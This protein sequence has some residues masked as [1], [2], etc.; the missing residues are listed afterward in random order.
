MRSRKYI[1]MMM[2]VII[3]IS[4]CS[5]AQAA[6]IQPRASEHLASFSAFAFT[7][8][9]SGQVDIEYNISTYNIMKT[10]GVSQIVI[11]K[12]NRQYV[13]TIGGSTSNGLLVSFHDEHNDV[14]TYT[15]TPGTS[16]YAVVTIY[17]Y[18]GNSSDSRTITTNTAKAA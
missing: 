6:D 4:C 12:S 2:F 5:F 10:I 16:Y 18:D 8:D 14:Y 15:G 11:Y 17:A 7:G 3:M 13:T 1:L 9:R